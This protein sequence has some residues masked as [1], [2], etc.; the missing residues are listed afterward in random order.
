MNL[1]DLYRLLRLAHVQAQNI[2]DTVREPLLGLCHGN[3]AGAQICSDAG[4]GSHAAS[5]A[6]CHCAAASARKRRSVRREIRWRCRLK[7]L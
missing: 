3:P 2:V 6:A 1:E 5:V 7:V 4:G